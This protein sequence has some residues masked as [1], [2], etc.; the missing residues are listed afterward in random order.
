MEAVKRFVDPQK[1]TVYVEKTTM[2]QDYL[3]LI[4]M[5]WDMS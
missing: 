3:E 1:Q 2:L 5:H 4:L